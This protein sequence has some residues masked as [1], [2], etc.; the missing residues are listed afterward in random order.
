MQNA[1]IP[2][3]TYHSLDD[4]GSV[5]S[6]SPRTFARQMETLSQMGYTTLALSEAAEIIRLNRPFPA[7]TFVV[8]FDDG[9]EN[10][11]YEAL[12]VLQRFGFKATVFLITD[13]CGKLNDW[14]THS[15][16][17]ERRPLISWSQMRE[18]IHSQ[19]EAGV[20]T[21]TH[22]DL[23]RITIEQ[24]EVEMIRSKQTIQDKLGVSAD[25]FAY[26]YGKFNRR[27]LDLVRDQFTA[28]CSTRLGK[29]RPGCD[30]HL[31]WRVD[32]YYVSS[33]RLFE[34]IATSGFNRYLSLRHV[35]RRL[36][37]SVA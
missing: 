13:Y 35:F 4:S 25:L 5:I 28:A 15:P 12:P 18:L 11:Y 34:T 6:T 32:M 37:E 17:I 30:P 24:A 9:Y 22:P 3:L 21:A 7:K 14:P 36:R 20:H 26:P 29:A 10:V 19:C 8:T 27:L 23:T 1:E 33:M 31:L 2:I 16:S